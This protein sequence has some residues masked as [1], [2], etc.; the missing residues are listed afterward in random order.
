MQ[1]Q[2]SPRRYL[3]GDRLYTKPLDEPRGA[4][5]AALKNYLDLLKPLA[6]HI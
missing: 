4:R 5:Q 2:V 6:T 3:C 1:E